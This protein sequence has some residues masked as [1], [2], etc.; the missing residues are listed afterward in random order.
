MLEAKP[1]LA[2]GVS[3]RR[4]RELFEELRRTIDWQQ[5]SI[6]MFA[7]VSRATTRRLAR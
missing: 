7:G 4:G 5:E 1:A 3:P 6:L 2:V